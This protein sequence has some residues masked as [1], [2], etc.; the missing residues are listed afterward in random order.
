MPACI[1]EN[2]DGTIAVIRKMGQ[3]LAR[4]GGQEDEQVTKD[5]FDRL[6]TL[7]QR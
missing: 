6:S 3:A 2:D 4:A 1:A 5:L 7:L